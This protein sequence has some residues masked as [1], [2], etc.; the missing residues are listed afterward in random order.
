[1]ATRKAAKLVSLFFALAFY[2]LQLA[3]S[4]PGV[5]LGGAGVVICLRWHCC[6]S[7]IR[8]LLAR[9]LAPVAGCRC[10]TPRAATF[11]GPRH[12][13]SRATASA[14]PAAPARATSASV[15]ARPSQTAPQCSA[16]RNRGPRQ[17]TPAAAR[18]QRNCA[19][20]S[21]SRCRHRVSCS[22]G[23]SLLPGLVQ[24]RLPSAL[25]L[26]PEPARHAISKILWLLVACRLP[27][28]PHLIPR[29]LPLTPRL[30]PTTLLLEYCYVPSSGRIDEWQVGQCDYQRGSTRGGRS[31]TE[32]SA[33]GEA[34]PGG[35]PGQ[36]SIQTV[37][38]HGR[39]MKQTS[40]AA[41][42]FNWRPGLDKRQ[43]RRDGKRRGGTI[44]VRWWDKRPVAG[45]VRE[46]GETKSGRTGRDGA[47]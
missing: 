3:S 1:M 31:G 34:R 15:R 39:K 14:S 26:V 9:G 22:T 12:A 42:R 10:A 19:M 30:L 35:T 41:G 24:R 8:G 23:S 25:R 21:A 2:L 4:F 7:Q 44:S 13:S 32:R 11:D 45:W 18:C 5:S 6:P 36:R 16:S 33:P 38:L 43:T 40:D 27:W 17:A 47:V 37:G 28:A 20:P 46:T 29:C